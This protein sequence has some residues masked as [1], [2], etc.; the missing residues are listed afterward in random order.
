MKLS[1]PGG[2]KFAFTIIDDTDDAFLGC[3][4]PIYDFLH[5]KGIR[6]TK[7]VWV[8]PPRD[9][10]S[11]GHS[12]QHRGYRAFVQKLQ[13]RGFEIGLHNVGSGKFYRNEILA[14]LEEY[15][16]CLGKYPDIHINHSYNADSIYGG[17][18]RFSFPFSMIVEMMHPAYARRYLGEVVGSPHFWGDVHKDIIRYSRNFETDCLNTLKF[19]PYMPYV[20][21]Q[22]AEF[23]NKWFSATFS[24]NQWVFKRVVTKE[25]IDKLEEE[26]GVCILYTH[27]GYYTLSG[28]IDR[29]FVDIITY[30]AEKDSVWLAP[31]STI[32][33]YLDCARNAGVSEKLPTLARWRMEFKYLWIRFK[34]RYL[35]KID[36]H[37]FKRKRSA[38][39]AK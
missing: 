32:L 3:I 5:S 34:Y 19:N 13:D 12:L 30:L 31:V 20:D 33:D 2:K 37:T 14:G 27:L 7:T 22:K 29:N 8:Y 24:P 15:K 17:N 4:E 28:E 36:D 10:E 1:F 35:V 25:A 38:M 18:K 26:G 23:A 6:S 9:Q 11:K 21:G 39:A 16:D